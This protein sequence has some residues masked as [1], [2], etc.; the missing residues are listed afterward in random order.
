MMV[1]NRLGLD[2]MDKIHKLRIKGENKMNLISVLKKYPT[3]QACIDH[4][5]VV[6]WKGKPCCPHCESDHVA[7]KKEKKRVGR[8]N[9]HDCQNSFN[10]L[11]GTVFQGTHVPLQKW[12]LAIAL[13]VNAKKSLS[14]CQ[15]ARDLELNQMS[16]WYMQQRIRAAIASKERRFLNGVVEM[17]ETYIGGKPRRSKDDDDL[18]KRGRGTKK[19]PVIGA[20][21]RGG[22]VIAKVVDDLSRFGVLRFINSATDAD[23][24]ILVTDEFPAYKILDNL[25][26]RVTINHSES[27]VDG[28]VHT[29]SIEGFWSHLKRAWFGQHH[30]YKKLYMPLYIAEACWK[31]NQRERNDGFSAFLNMAMN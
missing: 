18:P 13:M 6:R 25:L 16:C 20:V 31:Y 23:E 4:L 27:Y 24:T 29:N 30:H 8:W 7:R 17:D 2:K 9:C 26:A 14:S 22:K 12:F 11:S 19:T 10:V 28:D 3:Q 15:L 21:E 5:E 1:I